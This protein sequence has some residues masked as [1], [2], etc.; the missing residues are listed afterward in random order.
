MPPERLR[1]IHVFDDGC[2][3]GDLAKLYGCVSANLTRTE[4]EQ[5]LRMV[6]RWREVALPILEAASAADACPRLSDVCRQLTSLVRPLIEQVQFHTT[7][8]IRAKQ[9]LDGW[10]LVG[11]NGSL[12]RVG[13]VIL[14]TGAIPRKLDLPRPAIPLEVALCRDALAKFVGPND[15]VAVFGTSHSGTL[16][17]RNL[18]QVGCRRITA[19]YRGEVPFR[20]KRNHDSEGLKQESAAIADEIVARAWGDAT[21]TLVR[22]D[23]TATLVRQ[24]MNCDY[25]VYAI[26]FEPRLPELVGI[27][28]QILSDVRHNPATAEIAPA[29]WG[30]GIGFPSLYEKPLGG[31]A[32][33]VG[34]GG[35]I[36]H[37][38]S[39]IETILAS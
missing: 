23:D 9:E 3:G 21:P 1:D 15:S 4:I 29:M 5:A 35:F 19:F 10:T 28:G 24:V 34:F 27:G 39:R 16:V 33:D 6:P 22:M 37:I 32:P 14:C 13:R 11:N 8:I 20:W 2:I 31:L 18:Q 38:L 26:G 7:C 17:L 36:G 25:I 12:H 30:F